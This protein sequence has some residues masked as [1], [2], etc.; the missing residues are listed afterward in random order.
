MLTARDEVRHSLTTIDQIRNVE[1]Q[2]IQ[3]HIEDHHP[4]VYRVNSNPRYILTELNQMRLLRLS[5]EL[6]PFSGT[7][8]EKIGESTFSHLFATHP[9]AGGENDRGAN[10]PD[11]IFYIS[12]HSLP[13]DY[14]T[15]LGIVDTKS[16]NKA[17]F[18]SETIEGKHDGYL[19]R[20]RRQAVPADCR[21]HIFLILEF[22]GQQEIDFY[23]EMSTFYRDCEYM[24][25][26]TAEALALVMAAYLS[27][28]IANE[29]TLIDGTFHTAIYPFFH[30]EEYRD[31]NLASITRVVG[32]QQE[33]YDKEYMQ[34]EGLLII[35]QDVVK[36][37]LQDCVES[38]GEIDNLLSTYYQPMPTV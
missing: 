28:T 14:D 30:K 9:E 6:P 11:S 34:R 31:A 35:T 19:Q 21:A 3:Q 4:V 12:D 5:G 17:N 2:V 16:G 37:R 7:R 20:G 10:L 29:L 22:D 26:F 13:P 15:I 25:I 8:L 18:G 1:K 36:Q 24:V 23:D 33:T 38:P 27:H 32:Q